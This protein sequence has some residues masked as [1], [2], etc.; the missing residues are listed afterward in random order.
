MV[1]A[2]SPIVF[3]L[4]GLFVASCSSHSGPAYEVNTLPVISSP[5]P[6]VFS[7]AASGGGEFYLA[8]TQDR[9]LRFS[10]SAG[11]GAQWSP[12]RTVWS[13][14]VP[15]LFAAGELVVLFARGKGLA[16]WVSEDGGATW[17]GP[18][19]HFVRD[20]STTQPDFPRRKPYVY[21]GSRSALYEGNSGDL[22]LAYH[23]Q[24]KYVTDGGTRL[25]ELPPWLYF[26][27]SDNLGADWTPPVV[28]ADTEGIIESAPSVVSYYGV[29]YVCW[30]ERYR[31]GDLLRVIASSDGGATWTEPATVNMEDYV[32]A[33]R[34]RRSI[35]V[36]NPSLVQSGLDL[37][38]CHAGNSGFVCLQARGLDGPAPAPSLRPTW[39]PT[40]ALT[41]RR[42]LGFSLVSATGE[43]PEAREAIALWVTARH[44]KREWW[45]HSTFLTLLHGGNPSWVNNDLLFGQ[46][47]HPEHEKEQVLTPPL[48][49]TR[50]AVRA[51]HADNRWHVF[52][53]GKARVERSVGELPYRVFYTTVP[54]PL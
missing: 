50:G 20:S 45:G 34:E 43:P 24:E 51:L 15:T 47:V 17:S 39:T 23:H 33:E 22:Y 31:Y 25:V 9:E 32:R 49:Y 48:S 42:P 30:S 29:I 10:R 14:G 52:W 2:V 46:L 16:R 1:P 44:Q 37:Y 4:L 26:S 40:L 18:L 13:E 7:V 8:W 6:V 11:G 12:P 5:D 36:I 21:L 38:L 35:R 3:G 27:R 28:V 19:H 54:P 53:S 41:D